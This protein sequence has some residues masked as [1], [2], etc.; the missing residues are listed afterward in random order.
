MV[1]HSPASS[2]WNR[3]KINRNRSGCIFP[4]PLLSQLLLLLFSARL[5]SSPGEEGRVC[6]GTTGPFPC[7]RDRF[8]HPRL[9]R[10]LAHQLPVIWEKRELSTPMWCPTQLPCPRWEQNRNL[11]I[12]GTKFTV[13]SINQGNWW[14]L[15]FLPLL[16]RLGLQLTFIYTSTWLCGWND[17]E[18][19]MFLCS[20]LTA[21]VH[22]RVRFMRCWGPNL[23]S[24]CMIGNHDICWAKALQFWTISSRVFSNAQGQ[25]W[26]SD[27]G[28]RQ[29][30]RAKEGEREIKPPAF[31]LTIAPTSF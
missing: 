1:G 31:I 3:T 13:H 8:R 20:L 30:E 14:L 18:L 7:S 24:H 22:H 2:S 19:L 17:R 25:G 4:E 23:G 15:P 12:V 9:P 29:Q 6:W 10:R 5:L 26:V 16:V 11:W 21:G 27:S 28:W